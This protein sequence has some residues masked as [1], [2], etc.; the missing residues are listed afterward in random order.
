MSNPGIARGGLYRINE[1]KTADELEKSK[2]S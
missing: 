1:Y 2:F